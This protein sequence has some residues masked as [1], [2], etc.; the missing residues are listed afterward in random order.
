MN[1]VFVYCRKS[2]EQ[3]DRQV[4]SLD[5]QE[6]E[7]IKVVK[8]NNLDVVHTYK[9]SGS[10]H[11]IGRKCFNEMLSRI[12]NG[13]AQGIVVWDES[14]IARNSLDGGK[15]I[16][17]MDLKQIVEIYK[18]GKIYR[19]TPDDKSWM[20]M[21]FM[22]SKKESDDKGVNA[23]RGM[24]TKANMGWMPSTAPLGYKNT[25]DLKKG[26]KTIIKD[27]EHFELV[28][29]LFIEVIKGKQAS[30][31][32][33]E[34]SKIWKLT[35]QY[36]RI[37]SRSTV[38]NILTK[39]FYYGEFEYPR[40][41]GNWIKGEHEPMITR[42]EFDIVQIALGRK[43]KPVAHSHTF[44][45]T[46]LFRCSEC[47]SAITATTKTKYY[48]KTD[49][50]ATYVYYHCT[51]KNKKIKC[52]SEPLT[53][54]DIMNQIN[55]ILVKITPDQD[56]VEWSNRWLAVVHKN[57]SNFKVET[58]KSQQTELTNIEKRLSS[59]LDLKIDG[60]V[61][62]ETYT[63]KKLILEQEKNKIL[64]KLANTSDDLDDWRKRVENTIEF[65]RVS[66]YKFQNGTREDKQVI[67]LTIGS[68]LI[69]NNNKLLDVTLKNE[70]GVL[71]NKENWA[72]EYKGWLEPQKYTE[73]MDK[74]DDLRP[75]NP[76]W[77]PV[78]SLNKTHNF[79]SIIDKFQ[80]LKYFGEMKQRWL[81]IKKLSEGLKINVLSA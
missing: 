9:E 47:G 7:L 34:A 39:P 22:M 24:A 16:Y 76:V 55:N 18:P 12:E 57:E 19:N 46:G 28:R 15:V 29:R 45:L 33:E 37:I 79:Q 51:K 36:G 8:A 17:M 63:N 65:A 20:S 23:K 10:A 78:P 75:A 61:D 35:N 2:S 4:L 1:K 25:P 14:R 54:S 5:S 58:L 60:V 41:S 74:Y 44:D 53:E 43:G 6:V 13:E 72:T 26:F 71:A 38:Y 27:E 48:K 56:F 21:V 77:L 40:G 3:E 73:I 62:N 30:Q 80:E 11:V 31:V 52:H 49:R 50:F 81:E 42:E 68:N 66:Q 64:A 32:Y 67:L 70:Y 69:L 59:L